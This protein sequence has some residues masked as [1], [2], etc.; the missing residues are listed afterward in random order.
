MGARGCSVQAVKCE[1]MQ[2]RGEAVG[3]AR[4][5]MGGWGGERDLGRGRA[6]SG[7]QERLRPQPGV[8]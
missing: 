2:G 8:E 1:L 6:C 3:M 7:Y 5:K 4:C